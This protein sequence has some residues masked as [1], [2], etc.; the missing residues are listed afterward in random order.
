MS[1]WIE[2]SQ[3]ERNVWCHSDIISIA[4]QKLFF[5]M[6]KYLKFKI[7][8]FIRALAY[9]WTA[10]PSQHCGNDEMQRKS[11]RTT[12]KKNASVPSFHVYFFLLV[13]QEPERS[14]MGLHLHTR[15][16]LY[17]VSN[18][19]SH[20]NSNLMYSFC[21]ISICKW[22]SYV[23]SKSSERSWIRLN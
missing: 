9:L 4:F 17:T 18:V 22:L 7:G 1:I 10:S 5:S 2:I 3:F 19:N 6:E 20:S 14:S 23:M 16:P 21:R 8:A 12:T 13:K 11:T 15:Y